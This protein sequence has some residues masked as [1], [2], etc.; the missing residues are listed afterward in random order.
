MLIIPGRKMTD[1]WYWGQQNFKCKNH[2]PVS[3]RCRYL[4]W[5]GSPGYVSETSGILSVSVQCVFPVVQA[6]LSIL[7][8]CQ[9]YKQTKIQLPVV[10]V[11][12]QKHYH[13]AYSPLSLINVGYT[14]SVPSKHKT[15]VKHLY[16]ICTMLDQLLRH[17]DDIVQMLYKC[18]M[19]AGLIF[20]TNVA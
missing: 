9:L 19:F 2:S 7:L 12:L 16:N 14:P 8:S 18:F 4:D 13:H 11:F 6:H 1:R 15:F 17:W 5:W 20:I 3:S 10:C